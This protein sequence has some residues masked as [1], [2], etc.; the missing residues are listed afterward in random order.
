MPINAP[1]RRHGWSIS[2]PISLTGTLLR[3]PRS[4][5][6]SG[7]IISGSTAELPDGRLLI[8]EVDVA[9]LVHDMDDGETLPYKKVAMQKLFD[10][11]VTYAGA[12][13]G[14]G[15]ECAA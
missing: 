2:I 8:F 14:V 15:Y 1:S 9:M 7:S 4:I 3:S 12:L 6:E 13:R 10:A 11:F 5:V